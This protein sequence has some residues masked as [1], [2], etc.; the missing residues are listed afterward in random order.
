MKYIKLY[1]YTL[2]IILNI[3]LI[4]LFIIEPFRIPSGSMI[5]TL[6]I[7]DFILVNKFIYGIKNPITNSTLIEINKVKRGDIIVFYKDNKK[8][9]I[10]RVI[11][12]ENDLIIYENKKLTLN[13]TKINNKK[14][15][16]C[17]DFDNN[18]IIESKNKK[19]FLSPKKEYKIKEYKNIDNKYNYTNLKINKN[20]YFVMGDNRDNSEDSR[21]FGTIE[22]KNII[23]KAFIIW[24]SFD[25]QNKIIR[26]ER[27]LKVLK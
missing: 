20:S 5:P 1:K 4:R 23:G 3:L 26:S 9:Y 24:I 11:G 25:M 21:I 18:I 22:K 13:N 12:I 14:I 27:I 8:R 10:K 19:E 6:L 7:G 2:I 15:E 17:I 16:T